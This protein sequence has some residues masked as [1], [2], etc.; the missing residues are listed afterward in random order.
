MI[1][2]EVEVPL[3]PVDEG[4]IRVFRQSQVIMAIVLLSTC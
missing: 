2:K 4:L 1:A 3:Y